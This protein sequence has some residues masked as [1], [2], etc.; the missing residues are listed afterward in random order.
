MLGKGIRMTAT[1]KQQRKE[2]HQMNEHWYKCD[3]MPAR[4]KSKTK[5]VLKII[6]KKD[7]QTEG[8]FTVQLV[9]TLPKNK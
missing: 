9:N 6:S 3:R 2:T 7:S 8:I 4:S 5:C 1:A